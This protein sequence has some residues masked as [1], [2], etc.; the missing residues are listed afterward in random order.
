MQLFQQR[1]E[2]GFFE[3]GQLAGST[4]AEP[5]VGRGGAHADFDGDGKVDIAVMVHGGQPLL[6][7]NSTPATGHW[8]A[9]RLRQSER[10][11]Q[12]L[13]ARVSVRTG[14]LVQTAQVGTEGSYLSQA[15]SDLHFGLGA[16]SQVDEITIQ[17]PDGCEEKHIDLRPNRLIRFDH[18]PDYLE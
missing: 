13:G 11:T 18:A 5:V 9:I 8:L 3:S 12:A 16:A 10:N 6:L 15:H 4:F 1:P 2:E 17:W 7:R 14:N